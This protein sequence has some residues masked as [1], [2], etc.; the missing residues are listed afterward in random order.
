VGDCH[1]YSIV[2]KW[3]VLQGHA[4][5]IQNECPELVLKVHYEDVLRD[6]T[7]VVQGIYAF[8]GER[9]FGG[10]KRHASVMFMN[11]NEDLI[12]GAT[13]GR[14]ATKARHL[15]YQFMNLGR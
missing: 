15:S 8:I 3:T 7:N 5:R 10:I 2:K 1:Y 12:N 6:K 14:E 11:P 13:R 4:M 9:K